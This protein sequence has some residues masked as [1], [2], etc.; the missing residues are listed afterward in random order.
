M[1][2]LAYGGGLRAIL[3]M[4][5]M[6]LWFWDTFTALANS[7]E[8]NTLISIKF[9]VKKEEGWNEQFEPWTTTEGPSLINMP[10]SLFVIGNQPKVCC[11]D[12]NNYN[13]QLKHVSAGSALINLKVCQNSP[14]LYLFCKLNSNIYLLSTN[15]T[16]NLKYWRISK[17]N[18]FARWWKNIWYWWQILLVHFIQDRVFY[19]KFITLNI[20]LWI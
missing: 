17:R 8:K 11:C 1:A 20:F 6:K 9:H 16:Y 15:T 5:E 7:Q 2:G 10:W 18:F 3:V 4:G 13:Q 14:N 12:E 19:K